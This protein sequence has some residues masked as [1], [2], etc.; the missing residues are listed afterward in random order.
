MPRTGSRA[1]SMAMAPENGGDFATGS[2]PS[3]CGM[4]IMKERFDGQPILQ[5]ILENL[6]A[7]EIHRRAGNAAS[8]RGRRRHH[9]R[10][11]GVRRCRRCCGAERPDHRLRHDL[12][13]L[14]DL[15]DARWQ[16]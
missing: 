5:L 10:K 14:V 1:T 15:S 11:R 2:K 9:W 7:G 3:C 4:T 6:V 13:V 8:T 12:A 16:E